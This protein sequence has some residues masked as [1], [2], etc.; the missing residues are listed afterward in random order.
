MI[1]ASAPA[2]GI[3]SYFSSKCFF[4]LYTILFERGIAM[5][6]LSLAFS[7]CP[8]DT[9][10]FYGIVNKKIPLDFSITT[11]LRDVEVL[12][13]AAREYTFDISKLSCFAF[14]QVAEKYCI[15][16]SGAALGKGCG[17]LLL[18]RKGKT[19]D[20][21]A[22]I[23]IPGEM[24]T[25]HLLLRLFLGNQIKTQTMP[26]D[27]IMPAMQRGEIEYG[28]VIHE[29]RFT[30]Q[31]Y[32]LV[33]LQDLGYFWEESFH[34]PIP[35]GIIAG[36]REC[37][38]NMLKSFEKALSQSITYS[39]NN[40]GSVY[41][42][43]KQHAQEMQENVIFSHIDLYVTKESQRL[44]DEGQKAICFLLQKAMHYHWI[45]PFLLEKCFLE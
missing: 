1:I 19:L 38:K 29:G 35:L 25:A 26:F 27:Q 30:Y 23:A 16:R 2:G 21:H 41:P 7:P 22:T 15:L 24:T 13:R 43:I 17:P 37:G 18:A 28:V 8:N 44:S 40:R 33:C 6:N 10:M 11:T 45:E 36:K 14:G 4:I 34:L 32:N 12:N 31:N 5:K 9:F 39:W 20:Q 3:H 42:Y